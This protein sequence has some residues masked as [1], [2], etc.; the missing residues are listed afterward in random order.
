MG[1]VQ[2]FAEL[3]VPLLLALACIADVG[4]SGIVLL[5]CETGSNFTP[6]S[7]VQYWVNTS[8]KG[9]MR[10]A[11]N[12]CNSTPQ[13]CQSTQGHT[14]CESDPASGQCQRPPVKTCPACPKALS[15]HGVLRN[16]FK[17][18]APWSKTGTCVKCADTSQV[19]Q[20]NC[21]SDG[22]CGFTFNGT[23]RTCSP[24]GLGGLHCLPCNGP[25][26][27]A[28]GAAL[29]S[30]WC[31]SDPVSPAHGT[32]GDAGQRWSFAPVTGGGMQIK[33]LLAPE[34]C[35]TADSFSVIVEVCEGSPTVNSTQIWKNTTGRLSPLS[36]PGLCLSDSDSSSSGSLSLPFRNISLGAET[37]AADLTARLTLEE[38]VGMMQSGSEGVPR[39]ATPGLPTGEALHGV[40]AKCT[41]PVKTGRHA[42]SLCPTSFP[43]ML[44]VAATFSKELF[45]EIGAV[46]GMEARALRNLGAG[47]QLAL[48]SP[49]INLFRDPR[50]GRGQE[51]PGEDPLLTSMFIQRVASGMQSGEDPRYM[52]A[53][54]TPKHFLA[55][56]IEDN[57]PVGRVAFTANVS[58][59]DLVSYY[60]PAWRAAAPIAKGTMCSYNAIDINDGNG[61]IP[62]CGND[63]MMNQVY[64]KQ[65]LFSGY[66]VSDCDSIGEPSFEQYIGKR[67]DT[68]NVSDLEKW[69]ADAAQGV[70]GGC[71]MDCGTTYWN[72][73]PGSVRSAHKWINRST[74]DQSVARIAKHTIMLGLMDGEGVSPYDHYGEEHLDTPAHRQLAKDAATQSI[75]LMRNG[76]VSGGERLLPFSPSSNLTKVFV[77]GPNANDSSVLLSNYH[78]SN[79]L[80]AF[81]TPLAS[82]QRRGVVASYVQGCSLTGNDTS[83]IAAAATSAANASAA[84]LFLGLSSSFNSP[85]GQGGRESETHDRHT[86]A[87][88][89]QQLAFAKAVVAK[90]PKTVIVLICA[91]A[92]D[93][94]PLLSLSSSVSILWAGYGGE[95][96]GEAI[97]DVLLGV[98]SPSG[99]LA[100]SWYTNALISR[101][102][103]ANMDLRS[104][105]GI[106]YQFNTAHD[107][108][109]PFGWGLSYTSF[110]F[111]TLTKTATTSTQHM[112]AQHIAAARAT[113]MASHYDTSTIFGPDLPTYVIR[114]TN[115][116]TVAAAVT[117]LGFVAAT[118]SVRDIDTD[119]PL[120]ELFD[121]ERLADLAPGDVRTVQLAIPPGVL[122]LAD[123]NGVETVR[124]GEY[125]I[126]VG[127]EG[128]AE[129]SVAR[130]SLKVV[131]A[132]AV[133][134]SAPSSTN[135]HGRM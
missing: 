120:K 66:I 88:P 98:A 128:A 1:L 27:C 26:T 87:F 38:A 73:L 130:A 75:V 48:W 118:R 92:I 133:L 129:E 115:T 80:V 85:S 44:S 40:M 71:D 60:L 46:I 18:N 53:I 63:L 15:D 42:V 81:N 14:Y 68:Q 10:S 61:A 77:G 59:R 43:S 125:I 11:R 22:D 107:I 93:I 34:L 45:E 28:P 90:Q 82:L 8:M 112:K 6:S 32:V 134:F 91:G 131:G 121:F 65:F 9:G 127:V 33:S 50:W 105:G 86:L 123:A 25:L 29:L 62:S 108:T 20:N 78:G 69:Y 12:P 132:D 119:A 102:D 31:G 72:F 79:N 47:G 116:G 96:A 21:Q 54:C 100:T 67:Q 55:Y 70:I 3:V 16:P 37:R 36:S 101:R 49:D 99:R 57:E 24:P 106:T 74:I 35:L 104:Q 7:S 89:G 58:Q 113:A 94:T 117:V 135:I 64:R 5:P 13:P 110:K 39:L 23:K 122:S 103:I 97:A 52:Q 109:F 84:V 114:V 2:A 17:Y 19:C 95:L 56:D 126:E 30:D 124:S 83:E 41:K 111:E 51:V 76:N 4:L